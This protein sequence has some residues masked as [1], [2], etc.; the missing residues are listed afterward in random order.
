MTCYTRS[1]GSHVSFK[2]EFNKYWL[3]NKENY[4]GHFSNTRLKKELSENFDILDENGA[5]ARDFK[6]WSSRSG[7]KFSTY[8]LNQ[9]MGWLD[10]RLGFVEKE[11]L[12]I[13]TNEIIKY[14][15]K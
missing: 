8:D 5:Y 12:K 11:F 9:L 2:D 15:K 6:R 4:N 1:Y 7:S 3:E 14:K 10:N 13:D